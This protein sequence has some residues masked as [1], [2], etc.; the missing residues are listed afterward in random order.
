LAVLKKGF[1]TAMGTFRTI[2]D[3]AHALEPVLAGF[4]LARYEYLHSF[5]AMAVM[6]LL[7]VS[8]FIVMVKEKCIWKKYMWVGNYYTNSAC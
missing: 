7:A 1:G 3:I 6:P 5:G 8:I 2:F 4:L